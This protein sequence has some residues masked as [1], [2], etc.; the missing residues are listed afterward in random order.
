MSYHYSTD[1]FA[2]SNLRNN[3]KIVL[4]NV[5]PTNKISILEIGSHEGASTIYFAHELLKNPESKLITVDPFSSVDPKVKD[6][7][8]QHI[9]ECPFSSQILHKEMLSSDF[10]SQNQDKFNFIYVDGSKEVDDIKVDFLNCLNI[11]EPSGIIWISNYAQPTPRGVL[12][13]ITPP[14]KYVP[15]IMDSSGNLVVLEN[16][17][18]LSNSVFLDNVDPPANLFD[19][20]AILFD[21]SAILFDSSG[22][23]IRTSTMLFDPSGNL[24]DSSGNLIDLWGNLIDPSAN[25]VDP[26]ANSVDIYKSETQ[27]LIDD[28]F[29]QHKDQLKIVYKGNQIAFECL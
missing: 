12:S 5:T 18:S 14:E 17:G 16:V 21:P 2:N 4:E 25:S 13:H 22:N 7:F 19:P 1:W 24:I 23:L 26:S 28:L 27:K 15:I 3:F 9:S 20:S 11:I 29:E 10:Y 6:V 8:T